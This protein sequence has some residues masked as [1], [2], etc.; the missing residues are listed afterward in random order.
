MI[1]QLFRN[2]EDFEVGGC[3]ALCMVQGR[4][5]GQRVAKV[6]VAYLYSPAPTLALSPHTP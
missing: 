5:C 6:E 4:R 3:S 1:A 2:T